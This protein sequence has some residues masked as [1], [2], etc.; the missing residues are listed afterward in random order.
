MI[1]TTGIDLD[2]TTASIEKEP[3]LFTFS[4]IYDIEKEKEKDFYYF[5]NTG[6]KRIEMRTFRYKIKV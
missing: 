1:N 4:Y 5:F 6:K 3:N 2:D